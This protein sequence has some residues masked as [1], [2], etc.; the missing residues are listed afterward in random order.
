[1]TVIDRHMRPTDAFTFYLEKDPLLRSTV[2]VVGL[3]DRWPDLDVLRARVDRATRAAPAFRDRVATP[4]LRL[5]SP[6]WVQVDEIDLAWHVRHVAAAPPCGLAEVLEIARTAATSAFDPARPLWHL[7]VV[8]GLVGGRAAFVLAFHHALTDGI[9][10]IKLAQEIFD[11]E[12]EPGPREPVVGP[13]AEHL[14]GWRLAW[15]TAL[16]DLSRFARLTREAP[17]TALRSSAQLALHPRDALRTAA[18]VARTVEPFF[19]TKSPVMR[20]RRLDR[21][22]DVLDVPLADLHRAAS[23]HGCHLNDAFLAAVTG[24]LRR[25]HD[26]H[27]ADVK[28]LRITMPLSLRAEGDPDGGNRI[29]LLRFPLPV[30]TA[31]PAERMRA[32]SDTVLQ[33]RGERSLPYTQGIAA[34]LNLLPSGFI[35]SML[36]HVDFLASDVPGVPVRVYA[37]G[38]RVD[39]WYAF[40]PTTGAAVN[41]TLMSYVD[42]CHIGINTDT[43]AVPDPERL[44]ACLAEGFEEV[45]ALGGEHAP[46][47]HPG[48]ED[49]AWTS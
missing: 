27:D 39:S 3:L 47:R 10:G 9:G 32:I 21:A 24:G 36:K 2:V 29:T 28:D 43:G 35:G 41:I 15:D 23:L 38:A 17:G 34:A 12:R 40:G 14:E 16:Y 49:P 11:L 8:D 45:L 5:A 37:A 33:E 18:S 6:R 42:T 25:Y 13:P 22:L 1:M 20:D 26:E 46:V 7:T 31:D 44:V 4:P 48:A 30:S 19:R